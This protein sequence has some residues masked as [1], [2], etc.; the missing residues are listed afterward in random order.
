M[1]KIVNW[2]P[3]LLDVVEIEYSSILLGTEN[4]LEEADYMYLFDLSSNLLS[5]AYY[6]GIQLN[7]APIVQIG[8]RG[9]EVVIVNFD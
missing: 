5:V 9:F 6:Q 1:H 3:K 8:Q 4:Y 2:N 7:I